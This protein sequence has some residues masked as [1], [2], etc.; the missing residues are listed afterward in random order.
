VPI[1]LPF[2][3][4]ASAASRHEG[5]RANVLAS[6]VELTAR[7]S[8]GHE[9]ELPSTRP[10]HPPP[11][12]PPSRRIRLDSINPSLSL[13]V[14]QR[15]VNRG[16]APTRR[17]SAEG[18]AKRRSGLLERHLARIDEGIQS[19]EP[20]DLAVVARQLDRDPDL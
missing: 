13:W 6:S 11:C 7:S 1:P 14:G 20:V 12:Q 10:P 5:A 4:R 18:G 8:R 16:R 2:L 3:A 17:S 9:T 15:K 19:E